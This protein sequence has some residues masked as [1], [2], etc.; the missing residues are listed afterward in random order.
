MLES[1]AILQPYFQKEKKIA[2]IGLGYVGLP[3]ALELAKKFSVIGFDISAPRVIMM[4]NQIDPS[5]EL[6]SSAFEGADIL[7]THQI[8]DLKAAQFYIV[9]V[10]TPVDDHKIPDLL[11]LTRA[12]ETLSKV[13]KKGD[14]VVYESTVYP[15]CT[16]DDCVPVIENGSGL[17]AYIDFKVGYSPERINPGD[18][19]HTLTKVTKIVSGCSPESLEIIAGVYGAIIEPGVYKASSIK[20]AE[21]AKV[22]ENT[23]RDLNIALMN[24]LSQIF[25]IM[26]IN[27]Y[28]VLEAAG[29]KW[30]FLK[31]QP[32]LVGGHCIGVDPYY[33]TYKAM[34]QGYRPQIILAGRG[35]NDGMAAY[36]AKKVVQHLISQ[37]K[38]P[39]DSK[40][41]I[42]GATFKEDVSD[43]RNSKIFDLY[44]EL[45]DYSIQLDIVDPHASKEEVAHEYGVELADQ[46]STDYDSVIVA[47]AHQKYK[48]IDENYL[49]TILLPEG[50]VVD[51]KNILKGK[52]TNFAHW[53]L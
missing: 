20:V 14:I 4:K 38:N 42:L 31:F 28:D 1:Q 29:T 53:T 51:L 6:P 21:A 25:N 33:L 23:Q 17:K 44:K 27:T 13:I 40:V 41:L 16:E 5:K 26:N 47:V 9:A 11:P 49:K 19:E 3:I 10:P 45:K 39:K 8:E 22:I 43:I 36:V 24:E 35:I 52:I 2:V 32:G 18:T 7:F 34:Q 15:G 48:E 37:G 30:N 46:I 50:L 12:S